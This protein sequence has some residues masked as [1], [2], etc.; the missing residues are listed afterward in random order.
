MLTRRIASIGG[1]S[2]L[3]SALAGCATSESI[4]PD[5]SSAPVETDAKLA[6]ENAVGARPLTKTLARP[7]YQAIYNDYPGEKFAVLAFDY[8]KVP[9][10]YL[11]Q[12][13]AF[14]WPEPT[15][16]IVVDPR[17]RHLYFVEEPG[18]ATRYGV[19]VGR[20]G[21]LWS[22][23]AQVQFKRDWPDWVPPAEMVARSPEIVAQLE[24]T[25]RGLGVRGG[26]KSPLGARAMYLFRDKRDLGYRIHGTTEPETI[27]TS[28]SSGCVRMVNQDIAHLYT[29]AQVGTPVT[30]LA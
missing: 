5:A 16:S 23:D 15:G 11:R 17:A 20:D 10:R 9:R 14:P 27:G 19:G 30:V 29:R 4:A 6:D 2:A 22:G 28:V 12:T 25:P 26:P 24:Q 13:V 7:D 18:T 3:A 8:T 1:F 21:F